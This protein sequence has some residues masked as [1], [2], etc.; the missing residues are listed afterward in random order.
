MGQALDGGV[1]A[2]AAVRRA[3]RHS[4]ESPA[5]GA[6]VRIAGQVE[7]VVLISRMTPVRVR[8]R[9]PARVAQGV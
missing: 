7:V 4:Q 1:T 5:L 8:Q 2:T 9:A 6:R 3:I